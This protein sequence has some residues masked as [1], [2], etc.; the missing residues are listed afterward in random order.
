MEISIS[1]SE[2]DKNRYYIVAATRLTDVPQE[3]SNSGTADSNVNRRIRKEN[4]M[5]PARAPIGIRESPDPWFARARRGNH[6][7]WSALRALSSRWLGRCDVYAVTDIQ[8]RT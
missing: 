6:S 1:E 7:G 5:R 8:S 2:M 3:R 4:Y